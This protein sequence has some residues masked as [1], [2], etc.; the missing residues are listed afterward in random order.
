MSDTAGGEVVFLR[1]TFSPDMHPA[2]SSKHGN[3]NA[4]SLSANKGTV[5]WETREGKAN[6]RAKYGVSRQT[7]IVKR[8][9]HIELRLR[10]DATLP[11]FANPAITAFN[12]RG[13]FFFYA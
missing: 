3:K 7:K 1:L 8:T 9:R 4:N 2:Y 13:C 5:S 6:G 11:G 12:L 10:C